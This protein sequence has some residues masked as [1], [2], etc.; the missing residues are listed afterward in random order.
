EVAA[1]AAAKK[2]LS[3]FQGD[4]SE[5][6][7]DDQAP[8]RD[9]LPDNRRRAYK[10]RPILERICDAGSLFELRPEFGR[11][12]VTALARMAG[13]PVGILAND[14]FHLGGAL[15]SSA[16]DKAA[17]FMQLCDAF[18]LP[19]IS[20]CDTPGFMVGPPAEATALVRHASRMFISAGSLSV[21]FYTVIL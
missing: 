6:T 19:V 8:L 17:R 18:G 9:A 10:I 7:A 3:Y 14:T 11:S 16:A 20:F 5:W 13:R 21:P 1:V 15:D 2:C 12:V 4:V